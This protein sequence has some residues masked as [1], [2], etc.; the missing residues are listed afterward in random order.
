MATKLNTPSEVIA[1][2]EPDTLK[3][4]ETL[5]SSVAVTVPIDNW[6]STAL[7]VDPEVKTGATLS[8]VVSRKR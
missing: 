4:I 6:F 8:S 1:N 3:V 2:S 5:S 7:K